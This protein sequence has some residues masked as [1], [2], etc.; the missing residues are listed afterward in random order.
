MEYTYFDDIP[1]ANATPEI[2]SKYHE[3]INNAERKRYQESNIVNGIKIIK[4]N[5]KSHPNE[6]PIKNNKIRIHCSECDS[7]LEITEEDTHIGWLGARYITCPC[8]GEE[9]IVEEIDGITLTK[10]NIEFPKHFMR[11]N[12]EMRRVKEIEPPAIEKE[13][14]KGID[15]FRKNKDEWVWFKTYGDL[16]VVIFRNSEDEDYY[17][18]VTKDFYETYIPF[19][20]E[21]YEQQV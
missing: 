10:D 13:I 21:D 9:S 8:C 5:Y 19:E 3:C 20:R 16:F 17:I 6:E 12:K 4:N 18:T 11:T 7:E 15:Y 14:K 1:N 2:R